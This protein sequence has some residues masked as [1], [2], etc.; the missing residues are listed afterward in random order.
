MEERLAGL[1]ENGFY[2]KVVGVTFDDRQD[3]IDA[4]LP[5]VGV[6]L[7]REKGNIHDPYA[8]QVIRQDD[9]RQ[10]GYIKKDYSAYLADHAEYMELCAV[11]VGVT[12]GT[13]EKPEKGVNLYLYDQEG[14]P[15]PIAALFGGD[16]HE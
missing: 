1:L 3:A 11:V 7:V 16:S 10:V 6:F 9:G 14:R 12:G 2:T 8:I 13:K 4:S 15:L 5:Q